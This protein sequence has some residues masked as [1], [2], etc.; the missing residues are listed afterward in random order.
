MILD[1]DKL[2]S[3]IFYIATLV[4]TLGLF[5]FFVLNFFNVFKVWLAI[6][7]YVIF[8]L[9][10][11]ATVINLLTIIVEKKRKF[12]ISSLVKMLLFC[13]I[14]AF[15]VIY[16]AFGLYEKEV[17][18]YIYQIFVS[19]VLSIFGVSI[20]FN[21][22]KTK[23]NIV[24]ARPMF[25]I[26]FSYSFSVC[27]SVMIEC[28]KSGVLILLNQTVTVK[29][30]IINILMSVALSIFYNFIFYISLKRDKIAINYCIIE[31]L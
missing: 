3:N 1:R 6:P 20:F 28:I 7:Y 8:I 13:S 19:L 24:K 25:I 2:F 9:L 31:K 15:V 30:F 12:Y 23:D 14:I 10:I 26:L 27:I 5:T 17:F 29:L 4:I 22:M 16:P 18:I 11:V 21:S